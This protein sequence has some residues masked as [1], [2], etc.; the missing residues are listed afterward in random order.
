ML[1]DSEERGLIKRVQNYDVNIAVG[2]SATRQEHE[3]STIDNLKAQ[4]MYATISSN[5]IVGLFQTKF[6]NEIAS[7][8]V[9]FR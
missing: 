6:T 1:A 8:T 3:P 2:I 5:I 7:R 4:L 9:L